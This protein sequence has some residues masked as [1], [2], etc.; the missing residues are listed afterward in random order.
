MQLIIAIFEEQHNLTRTFNDEKFTYNGICGFTI[1][2]LR[3]FR[4]YLVILPYNASKIWC[5]F[6][7]LVLMALG[8]SVKRNI[9]ATQSHN[10]VR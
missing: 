8:N 4:L 7:V 6:A 2:R 10:K 3:L 1:I 5:F 9:L